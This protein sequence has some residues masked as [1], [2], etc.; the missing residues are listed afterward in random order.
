MNERIGLRRS[1]RYRAGLHQGASIPE[2]GLNHPHGFA[3]APRVSSFANTTGSRVGNW[4]TK[5]SHT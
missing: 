5:F 2:F 4:H 1:L 3:G